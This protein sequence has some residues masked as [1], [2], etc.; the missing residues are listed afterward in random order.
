MAHTESTIMPEMRRTLYYEFAVRD[1]P[2]GWKLGRLNGRAKAWWPWNKGNKIPAP[3]NWFIVVPWD[4]IFF[5]YYQDR[6][7]TRRIKEGVP[8]DRTEIL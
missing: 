5:L 7:E 8:W 1:T 2:Q 4:E 6:T 3:K